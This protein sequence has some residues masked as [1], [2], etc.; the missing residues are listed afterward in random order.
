M[1]P[2]QGKESVVGDTY[3]GTIGSRACYTCTLRGGLTDV[4]SNWRLWNADMKVYRDG[5]GKYEDEETF[6]SIDD[7]VVSKIEPRRKAI[8]WFSISEAVREKFLTD[9]GSRDKTSEDVMRRLFDNV[10]PEGSK[11]KPLE[12]LVVEDHMRE[13]IRRERESKRVAENGQGKP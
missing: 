13:S 10:A 8:L 4:D 2:K 9:M 1:A 3:L 5:E 6:P 7:D 11:Y 12:R